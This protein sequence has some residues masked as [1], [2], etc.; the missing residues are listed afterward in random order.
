MILAKFDELKE[1]L[2]PQFRN[3]HNLAGIVL[4]D[5]IDPTQNYV[6]TVS[7]GSLCLPKKLIG[8][9]GHQLHDMHAEVLA[10]R[11]LLRF[12]YDQI[13]A[14]QCKFKNFYFYRFFN[15]PKKIVMFF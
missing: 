8:R 13:S 6:I 14:A 7:A 3:Y 5:K 10:R 15:P 11:A 4:W 9:S 12:L 1:H 2:T